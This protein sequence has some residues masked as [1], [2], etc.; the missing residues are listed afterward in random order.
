MPDY[1]NDQAASL[2]RLMS[3]PKPRIVSVLSAST[4]DNQPRLMTNL[5]ASIQ[6][7]GSDVL[8]VHAARDTCE[9]ASEYIL[10]NAPCLMDVACRKASLND[11]IKQTAQGFSMMRLLQRN[12]AVSALKD[13]END[14]LDRIF[15]RLANQFEI[16]LVDA[17]LNED[18]TLPLKTLNES[19]ILI[20]LTRHPD[21]I[22]QAYRLI[23][24]IYG[25]LGRRPFGILVNGATE[26]QAQAVF[27]NIFQVA[28]RHLRVEPEFIGAIPADDHLGRAAK[29][30]RAVIDAFPMAAASSAFKYLAQ[31]IDYKQSLMTNAGLASFIQE[32]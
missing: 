28:K 24:Q 16:V 4:Q 17:V 29:L 15:A 32:V 18:N 10:G 9:S 7:G 25:Q 30:G 11:A 1:K 22:K 21:S 19:D 13:T 20:Q 3:G 23:K 14:Q 2:R 8:L 12:Q 31:R 27:R 6:N 26:Q 5:A